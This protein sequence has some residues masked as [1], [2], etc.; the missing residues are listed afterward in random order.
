M[1]PEP[2]AGRTLRRRTERARSRVQDTGHHSR[3]ASDQSLAAWFW[4]SAMPQT[5]ALCPAQHSFKLLVLQAR[6][7]AENVNVHRN[8]PAIVL[9]LRWAVGPLSVHIFLGNEEEA[10][11]AG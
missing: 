4:M 1:P 10:R 5:H 11:P 2:I 8:G 3:L 7:A 9:E 6:S